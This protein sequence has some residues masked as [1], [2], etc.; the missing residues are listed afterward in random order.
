MSKPKISPY[1]KR[2]AKDEPNKKLIIWIGSAVGG[3]IVAMTV[4]LIVNG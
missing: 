3:V 1:T 4:L 2:K